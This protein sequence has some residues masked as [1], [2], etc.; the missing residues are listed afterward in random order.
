MWTSQASPS[1]ASADDG[2]E[3]MIVWTDGKVQARAFGLSGPAGAATVSVEGAA[4]APWI[5]RFMGDYLVFWSA[6]EEG[7]IGADGFSAIGSLDLY[8]GILTGFPGVGRIER[9]AAIPEAQIGVT[10]AW[11]AEAQDVFVAW[12]DFRNSSST[13]HPFGARYVGD[14]FGSRLR[15][16]FQGAVL[17]RSRAEQRPLGIATADG[18]IRAI[19]S[20]D[21]DD[22]EEG[23]FTRGFASDGSATDEPRLIA[24]GRSFA[25]DI[26]AG[27]AGF[28][29][30]WSSGGVFTTLLDRNGTP[31]GDRV[32]IDAAGSFPAIASDGRDFLVTWDAPMPPFEAQRFRRILSQI[33]RAGGSLAGIPVELSKEPGEQPRATWTGSRYLVVWSDTASSFA[34]RGTTGRFVGSSGAPLGAAPLVFASFMKYQPGPRSVASSGTE[35][36]IG[37]SGRLIATDAE[38]RVV[39]LRGP[40][41][42]PAL[43]VAWTGAVFAAAHAETG[44][45][46]IPGLWPIEIAP[47]GPETVVA[48]AAERTMPLPFAHP[49]TITRAVLAKASVASDRKRLTLRP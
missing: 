48:I 35:H 29:I 41:L 32:T 20:E 5:I 19:W 38:G 34:G 15:A 24:R 9:I 10:A 6:G 26:A 30:A 47:A 2:S 23:L 45:S 33:V 44:L 11:N 36:L 14:V 39:E 13:D 18:A 42:G 21:L 46:S 1:V 12:T 4:V 16:G 28:A 8:A 49:N 17:A 31:I 40:F 43:S 25:A 22:D 3:A 27:D 37:T 7:A